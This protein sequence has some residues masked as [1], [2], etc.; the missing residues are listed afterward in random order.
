MQTVH[1]I[2]RTSAYCRECQVMHDARIV[3]RENCIYGVL[4]CPVQKQEYLLSANADFFIQNRNRSFFSYIDRN[5][6][7]QKIYKKPYATFLNLTFHCDAGCSICFANAV[8]QEH[9]QFLS[10][11]QLVV[12]LKRLKSRG[13]KTVS[14]FGGEPTL[15]PDILGIIRIIKKT[16]MRAI[17]VTNGYRLGRDPGFAKKVK[18]AGVWEVDIQFDTLD[19]AVHRLLRGD[20]PL[21]LKKRA[22]RNIV[23][24]GIRLGI[25][26]TVIRSN[27]DELPGLLE[28]LAGLGPLLKRVMI[29]GAVNSG[30]FGIDDF[31]II[32]RETILAGICSAAIFH[33]TMHV[34][35][36]WP[37]PGIQPWGLYMHPDCTV[38]N[39]VVNTAKKTHT[40]KDLLR[41]PDVWKA[42]QSIA[43]GR[44][45]QNRY[46]KP[47]LAVIRGLRYRAV[48]QLISI[49]IQGLVFRRKQKIAMFVL[50][51]ESYESA[52]FQDI[53]K[54]DF[55]PTL[56]SLKDEDVCACIYNSR[57]KEYHAS[58]MSERARGEV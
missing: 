26:T 1:I 9:P 50:A 28:Y 37:F 11:E 51:V 12:R 24:A 15:H 14:L 53:E 5:R 31:E 52:R 49:A 41:V 6:P 39:V 58:R 40:M 17:L 42:L 44:T 13:I 30:R 25:V 21:S 4:D 22:L 34:N 45:I 23:R 55:C 3:R 20:R 29:Q 54:T 10:A 8:Y 47:L 57:G 18:R 27:A 36:F 19:P 38:V 2:S 48:I 46:I 32:D 43:P 16:G 56:Q 33:T 35:D 7:V